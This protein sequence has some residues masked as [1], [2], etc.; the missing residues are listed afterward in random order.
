MKKPIQTRSEVTGIQTHQTIPDALNHA[1]QDRTVWKISFDAING[2]RVRLVSRDN[3]FTW[4]Y[5]PI[6]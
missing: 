3:G 4:I 1:K 6:I 2:D 5:E